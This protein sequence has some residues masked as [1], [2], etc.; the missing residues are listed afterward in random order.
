MNMER[1]YVKGDKK[2]GCL[3]SIAMVSVIIAM[4]ISLTAILRHKDNQPE[5]VS[6]HVIAPGDSTAAPASA[7]TIRP[8]P[9]VLIVD[10]LLIHKANDGAILSGP[11]PSILAETKHD[12][13]LDSAHFARWLHK[14]KAEKKLS[15][16]DSNEFFHYLVA[17]DTLNII[18]RFGPTNFCCPGKS[19]WARIFCGGRALYLNGTLVVAGNVW[20]GND[21]F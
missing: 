7:D 18:C 19:G 13:V 14:A 2:P 16:F 8:M 9:N 10:T 6:S 11:Y 3:E 5:E 17:G 1:T 15:F 21:V 4:I 20:Y 12:R